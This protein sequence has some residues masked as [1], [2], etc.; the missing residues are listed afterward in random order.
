MY[1]MT[2]YVCRLVVTCTL[3]IRPWEAL[4]GILRCSKACMEGRGGIFSLFFFENK[5]EKKRN[6]YN[7][8]VAI[9][10]AGSLEEG[11]TS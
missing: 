4:A 11:L 2:N 1:R 9:S 5:E 8:R 6:Q 10:A 7:W 3:C